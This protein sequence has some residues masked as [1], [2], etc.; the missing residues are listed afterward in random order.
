MNDKFSILCL[1]NICNVFGK[2]LVEHFQV[3]IRQLQKQMNGQWKSI[4]LLYDHSAI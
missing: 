2:Q 1:Y 4:S 3:H